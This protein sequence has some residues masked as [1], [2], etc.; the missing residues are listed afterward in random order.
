M[1]FTGTQY[2]MDH[3]SSRLVFDATHA[4]Q[5]PCGAGISSSG[6]RNYVPGLCRAASAMG[7][8]SFFLEVHP[9]PDNAPSDG[10]NMLHLKDFESVVQQI[11]EF[12][13][14]KI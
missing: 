14:E 2:I 1:D 12:H 4:V 6:N 3:Y 5:R 9:D 11:L 13:Y 7:V 10:P 8:D